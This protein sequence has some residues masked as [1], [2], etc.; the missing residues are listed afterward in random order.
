MTSSLRTSADRWTARPWIAVRSCR[1]CRRQE[2]LDVDDLCHWST[3]WKVKWLL[4]ESE[5]KQFLHHGE[6]KN[7]WQTR[8][9]AV[10]RYRSGDA[11]ESRPEKGC[12][13]RNCFYP[14]WRFPEYLWLSIMHWGSRN[15]VFC[16]W[17]HLQS[18][19]IIDETF[20][21]PLKLSL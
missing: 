7:W 12:Y 15:Y 11:I 1:R 16:V 8:M 19:Q 20:Q 10:H 9:R 14:I 3:K 2:S 5:I 13:F 6:I 4:N 17:Q 18:Y 21:L